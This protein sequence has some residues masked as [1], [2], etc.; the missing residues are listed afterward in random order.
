MAGILA[1]VARTAA[2]APRARLLSTAAPA[3]LLSSAP[4]A[5][6]L[7]FSHSIRITADGT[8]QGEQDMPHEKVEMLVTVAELGLTPPEI[9]RLTLVTGTRMN[10]LTGTLR[11]IGRVHETADENKMAV[12]T[13]LRLLVED[14]IANAG[15]DASA[16]APSPLVSALRGDGTGV[17]S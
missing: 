3:E 6:T 4:T 15:A 13:Q 12:R 11:L 14:A 7:R 8:G 16:S 5:A 2:A 10:V 17:E 9:A 1:R